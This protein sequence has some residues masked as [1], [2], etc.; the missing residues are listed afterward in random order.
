MTAAMRFDQHERTRPLRLIGYA[1][2]STT[3][4]GEQG[5]G[6]GFRATSWPDTP[7]TP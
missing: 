7:R 6:L 3:A 1:R 2:V 5:H 4:Q